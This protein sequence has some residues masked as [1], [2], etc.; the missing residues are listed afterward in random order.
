MQIL[1]NLD[2]AKNE[3]QNARVQNLG[4]APANP[5]TGQIYFS[6]VDNAFYG[7]NGSTWIDLGQVL[8]GDNIITLLNG[9][10]LPI[11]DDNLS[12]NVAD[13]LAKRHAHSNAAILNAMEVAFT[14]ALKTKLDGISTGATKTAQSTT[15]GNI[16]IDGVEK[17]VYTHPGS[18][19]NPHGTT[20]ADVGLG[21]VED[22]SS[23]TIRGEIT[24]ANVT[25]ALGFT[26]VKNGGSIPELR[27]GL[28]SAMPTATGSGTVYLATDTQKIYKDTAASTWTQ[29]GGQDLPIASASIL[30]GIKVGANLTIGGDG[31]LNAN[32]NPASFIIKHERFTIAGGQTSF[33]LT[34]GTYKPGTHTLFWF[35]NGEKQDSDALTES[36]PTAFTIPAGLADGNEILAEYFETINANPFPNHAVEHLSTGADPIP[37]AAQTQDGLMSSADKTKLDGVDVNANNYVH[38]SGDGNLH[39]PTTGTTNNG[40][41]LKAGATAGSISWGT[42]AAADVGAV[43]TTDVVTVAAANKILKLDA[44]SKLPAS[45]TGNADG[46]AATATKLQAART[47]SLT[48]DA[49]GSASFDGSANASI[50]ATLA[51]SGVAAGTYPKV[52]VDTKGRV[53]A[54][55]ALVAGDI[56]ILTHDKISDFDAG[57]QTN[58]LDQM[59]APSIDV[60]LN[61]K[62]IINLA[63]PVSGKDAVTKDY[64]DNLR[65]GLLVKDP[66][67]V[68]TT[69][70]VV[71][72]TGGLLTIDGVVLVAGDRVLVKSQT[73]AYENGIYVA[74]A[75]AWSRSTDADN[76]VAGEVKAGLCVWVNEGTANSDSRWVLTTN[77][78]ITLG[79]TNLTFTKDFQASDLVAGTGLSKAGN[80]LSLTSGV[81]TAGTY[82]SVTVDTYGRVTAGSNPTTLSGYG[83]TDAVNTSDVVTAPA[84]SKI[85]KLDA[86][87]KLPSSITGNADGNAA[88]ATKLQTSR[89]LSL[90]GDVTGSASFDGSANAGIAATLANSGVAAGTYKSVT[91]DAK[92]RVTAATNP[93]TL[94]GYGIT[95]ATRK[96]AVALGDGVTTQF[97]IT[98]NL[99]SMDVAITLRENATPYNVAICDMQIVD[100]N[101][102]KLLFGSAAPSANQYRVTIAG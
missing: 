3:L 2:L 37:D 12:A 86:N 44:N 11:D 66:V 88:T 50:A 84:A 6:T 62:K 36:S 63:E 97:T 92:G 5:V 34:K 24:S 76:T 21:S 98:H 38:P 89:T 23:A 27:G 22:K 28:E 58:R 39:V 70:N 46:N 30:G 75:G 83:I 100:V 9:S 33:T 49:T 81:A 60:S 41:V 43:P 10:A 94:A 29:M 17:T 85:L 91:V 31:T 19:T 55:S 42:L 16:L 57:V 68:A 53:T 51:N 20:K 69:A 48:G 87:S 59:A 95:D 102:I 47:I 35:L 25:A 18:G 54:G 90:S 45:I 15:N 7:W 26:P 71:L 77:D 82:K 96:F 13:A 56:P 99:G 67:R 52:T 78:L 74:A 101:S 1:T 40:K 61:T 80:T 79:T 93:T 72:A 65:A 14:N 8:T 64:A 4:A 73:N 32:D